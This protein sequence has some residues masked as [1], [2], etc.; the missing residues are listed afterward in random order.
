MI[1]IIIIFF[2]LSIDMKSIQVTAYDLAMALKIVCPTIG[3]TS[4]TF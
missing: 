2:Y 1:I 4:E 3:R